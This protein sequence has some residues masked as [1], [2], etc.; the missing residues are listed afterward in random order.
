MQMSVKPHMQKKINC[1]M[2]FKKILYV[3]FPFRKDLIIS[4]FFEEEKMKS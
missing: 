3:P 1:V 2:I 4:S